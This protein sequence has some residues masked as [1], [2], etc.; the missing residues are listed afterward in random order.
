MELPPQ[1]HLNPGTPV[2]APS[3]DSLPPPILLNLATIEMSSWRR[4]TSLIMTYSKCQKCYNLHAIKSQLTFSKSIWYS[5]FQRIAMSVLFL[6]RLVRVSILQW[7]I[8]T[9]LNFKR[10]EEKKRSGMWI[11]CLPYAGVWLPVT[12]SSMAS[13]SKQWNHHSTT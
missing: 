10:R 12:N 1:S 4:G 9:S 13:C 3:S 7:I 11:K 5:N 2:S 8:I 6:G